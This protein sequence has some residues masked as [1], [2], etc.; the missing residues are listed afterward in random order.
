M[1]YS[2]QD[3]GIKQVL[4]L[5]RIKILVHEIRLRQMALISRPFRWDT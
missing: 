5:D 3:G 4:N 1:A 2:Q